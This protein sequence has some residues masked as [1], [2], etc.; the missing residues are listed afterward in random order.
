MYD[1]QIKKIISARRSKGDT[2]RCISTDMNISI[3]SIHSILNRKSSQ[4]KKK[5]GPKRKLDKTDLV[6]IKRTINDGVT[7]GYKVTSASIVKKLQLSVSPLTVRR[8]LSRV[9]V[10]YKK[11]RQHI[12]LSQTHKTLRKEAVLGWIRKNIQW[13]K[14]V[15]VNLVPTAHLWAVVIFWWA[16]GFLLTF[17]I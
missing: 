16:V 10:K 3:S 15:I 12:M 9:G 8:H 7:H 4:R 14:A 2:F 13:S 1:D 11:A 17:N 6:S 5:T